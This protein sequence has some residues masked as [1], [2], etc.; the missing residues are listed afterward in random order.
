MTDLEEE[1]ISTK[2]EAQLLQP[3]NTVVQR[4]TKSIVSLAGLGALI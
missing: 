4:N 1:T 2:N 3:R